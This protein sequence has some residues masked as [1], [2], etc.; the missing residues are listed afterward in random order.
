MYIAHYNHEKKTNPH[1]LVDH[2]EAMVEMIKGFT[3]S[4]DSY[5]LAEASAI[6]HD[7]GKK[8]KPFQEYVQN[9]R[10]R[11]GTVQHAIGG[12][13]A[14]SKENDLLSQEDRFLAELVQLIVVGHHAGL[15]NRDKSFFE[16]YDNLPAEQHGIEKLATKEVKTA[17]SRLNTTH[18]QPIL[19]EI[20]AEKFNLYVSTLVR[21]SMSAMV[22]ADYLDTEAYFSRKKASLR[23]YDS[24]SF[25]TFTKSFN[26]YI[27]D[28]F[29]D[30][31]K[32]SILD[33]LKDKVQKQAMEAGSK[34]GTFYTLHAPTGTGKTIAALQFALNHTKQ[35]NKSRIITA[36]PLMNLTEEI[37][38]IY[39]DIFG[40]EHVIEDHSSISFVD[41]TGESLIRHAAENWDR[42]LIVTT[43][44]QLFESLF[45]HRPTKLRK[46]HRL[47]NSI[48]ILDEYHKLPLHVLEPILQQLDVLQTH[49]NITVLLMSATPFPLFESEKIE[50]MD[51]LNMPVEITSYDKLFD[52][53]PVRVN[54]EWEKNPLSLKEVAKRL[55]KETAVLAIVNTRKE[56]QLLHQLLVKE[57][58][59]FEQVYYISTT[60]S[61]IHRERI[62]REIKSDRDVNTNRSIAVISTSILEAGVDLSFPL[63]YRMIA[64]LDAIV[65]AAGRC[66]R[67][68]EIKLGR[69]VLFENKLKSQLDKSFQ[70]GINQTKSLLETKGVEAFSEPTSFI[71]FYKRT[72][73]DNNLNKYDIS[74]NNCFNF[75]DV[76]EDFRM[77]KGNRI[78]V[79]C[80][81]IDGFQKKW[82]DEEKSSHW[83]RKVQP[84]M[85]SISPSSKSYKKVNDLYV[86]TGEYDKTY[87]I[88]L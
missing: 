78:S 85:V 22:D 26:R 7:V 80:P 12:A 17:L 51:L 81:M 83:W 64:P 49:F 8:C 60:M 82:L 31:R 56:A 30:K 55:A 4:F 23:Q 61:S 25:S 50:K 63:V 14:F 6:L 37:S 16:K 76:S 77:I 47:A 59:S 39:R 57:D 84:F 48:I 58:H 71:S 40:S 70:A 27:E 65:Q 24:P 2:V 5:G 36:L 29:S 33:K 73:S 87:G 79:V 10:A 11:R 66:N 42:S 28:K 19:K 45:H 21:F 43:T 1:Y 9:P 75:K 69:I 13:Y 68:G 35:N 52:Q 67:Y 62:L 38:S 74:A 53:V 41:N 32:R 20:G 3:Y 72:F 46:L 54:Y 15:S 44:V 86:F 34:D 18:L 88:I